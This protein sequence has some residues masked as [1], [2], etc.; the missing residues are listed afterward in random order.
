MACELTRAVSNF[1]ASILVWTPIEVVLGLSFSFFAFGECFASFDF[2]KNGN[3][4]RYCWSGLSMFEL[5][6]KLYLMY[7]C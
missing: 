4:D 3:L 2:G 1:E 5:M 6:P 7:C